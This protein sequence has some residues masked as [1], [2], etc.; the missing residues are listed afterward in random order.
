MINLI[1]KGITKIFGSKYEKDIKEVM[2]YVEKIK[3]EYANLANLTD[4][5]IRGKT[6]DLRSQIDTGL[7]NIDDQIAAGLGEG[8]ASPSQRVVRDRWGV[9]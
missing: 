6:K 4:E 9:K 5:E 3:E 7:K 2:P 1:T 8:R